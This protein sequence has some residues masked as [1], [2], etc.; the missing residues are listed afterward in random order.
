[1]KKAHAYDQVVYLLQGGGALG[2]YQA[3]VCEALLAYGCTPDWLIGTSIGAINASIIAGNKPKHRLSKLKE[4]WSIVSANIPELPYYDDYFL[5]KSQNYYI[6]QYVASFGVPGF[7]E[8][9]WFNPWTM[10][11][12]TPDNLSFYDTSALRTTLEKV[13]DFDLINQKKIR[14]T[15]GAVC[16]QKGGDVHFDNSREIIGPE[17]IMASAALPPGFPAIK[18]DGDYYWDG[19]VSSNTPL[20]IILEE[21]IPK[22]LLCILVNLFSFP[23]HIPTSLVGVMKAKKEFEYASRHQEIVHQ[24]LELHFMQRS[25]EMLKKSVQ[26]MPDF[27]SALRKIKNLGHPTFLNIARFH[28][29]DKPTNLDSSDFNFAP[30]I[31]KKHWQTGLNDAH[32]ALENSY[33]LE[34]VADDV[35]AVIHEF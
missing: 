7:F 14:L 3:G 28:Y 17:H 32:S 35:G 15:L 9:R 12:N 5:Q 22:K 13:I 1:M 23:E 8:P 18:I 33:W 10:L 2:S 11:Y 24:F 6:A 19:G 30:Q 29:K 31:I 16:L 4:F 21:R 27:Q 34:T 20:S 25:M 26:N